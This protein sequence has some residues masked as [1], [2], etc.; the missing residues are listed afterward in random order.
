M[1]WRIRGGTETGRWSDGT[2]FIK[3]VILGLSLY[4]V[5]HMY[6]LF[7]IRICWGANMAFT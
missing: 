2:S 1:V 5:I 3:L 4:C 7:V 6:M